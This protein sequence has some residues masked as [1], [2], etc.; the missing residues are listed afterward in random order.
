[1]FR[2]LGKVF[3]IEDQI[4]VELSEALDKKKRGQA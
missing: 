1:M 2:E 3:E 4:I